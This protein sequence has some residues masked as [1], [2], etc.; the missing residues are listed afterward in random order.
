MPLARWVI[1]IGVLVGLGC[2]QVA[3]R[4][5]IVV[6]GYG[7]GERAKRV[8]EQEVDVSWR[9]TQVVSLSSPA[10]L[11][12]V[13]EDRRLQLKAWATLEAEPTDAVPL[14][15]VAALGEEVNE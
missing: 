6:K 1:L 4:T 11:L 8:H 3:Q 9:T 10:H 14:A 2:L 7:V 15:R 12:D 5:A 13:A